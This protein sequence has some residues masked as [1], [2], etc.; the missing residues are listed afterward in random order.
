[1][2]DSSGNGT[3]DENHCSDEGEGEMEE[4]VSFTTSQNDAAAN[5]LLHDP[6]SVSDAPTTAAKST[7]DTPNGEKQPPLTDPSAALVVA[8]EDATEIEYT[9]SLP[10]QKR[11][12]RKEQAKRKKR[13]EKEA[14][15]RKLK[16]DQAKA[17]EEETR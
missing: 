9:L 3:K 7:V 8:E 1:M 16:E 11:N 10:V 13:Q 6:I 5:E 12:E 14:A 2:D 4:N 15:K 17:M